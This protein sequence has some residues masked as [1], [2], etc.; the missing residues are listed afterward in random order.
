MR[1]SFIYPVL[2]L[3]LVAQ[4]VGAQDFTQT[5]SALLRAT[6]EEPRATYAK[7]LLNYCNEMLRIVPRNSPRETEWI[8]GEIKSGNRERIF[9][10][11]QSVEYS[12]DFLVDTF[13][14]CVAHSD[15]LATQPGLQPAAEAVLWAR[16]AITFDYSDQIHEYASRLGLVK[17]DDIRT[18][19]HALKHLHL[20]RYYSLV[21]VIK[22]LGQKP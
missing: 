18:D 17:L 9:R 2:I 14:A 11:M 7:T 19:I 3:T 20:V 22:S 5:A 1:K 6:D 13:T 12:R 4:P 16:L 10:A 15:K 21:A 8:Q